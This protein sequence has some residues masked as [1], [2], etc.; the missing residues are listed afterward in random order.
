MITSI[1]RGGL[2]NQIF[3]VIVGY[4]LAK[5]NNDNYGININLDRGR[6]QG[7]GINCYIDSIFLLP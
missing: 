3:Q 2:G 4:F 6:G 7:K 1:Y 5:E